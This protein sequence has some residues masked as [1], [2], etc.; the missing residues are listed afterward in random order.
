MFTN[1]FQL[2]ILQWHNDV[3]LTGDESEKENYYSA[4]AIV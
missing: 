2:I 1:P 4:S 3:E